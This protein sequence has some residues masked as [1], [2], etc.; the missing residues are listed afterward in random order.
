MSNN[1]SPT[2]HWPALLLL[3]V[4][5]FGP[6]SAAVLTF[7]HAVTQNPWLTA[8]LIVIYELLVFLVT[9]FGKVWQRLEDPSAQG[10]ADWI[11]SRVG[12]WHAG[13]RRQ[14]YQRLIYRCRHLENKGLTTQ[15]PFAPELEQVFVDL[16]LEETT[17][18]SA[19]KGP[20][21]DTLRQ[22]V[23]LKNLQ[24]GTHSIWQCLTASELAN[25]QFVILGPAGSGKTTLSLH[26]VLALAGQT[27]E[28]LPPVVSSKVPVLL[29]LR[30]LVD[31]FEEQPN[32][33]LV[34]AIRKQMGPLEASSSWIYRQLAKRRCLILLD[35][36][37]EVA[38]VNMRRKM[39]VW[40]ERQMVDY[41][42]N[43]F[44]M[45]SRPL[46]YRNNPLRGVATF[47][48]QP[49]TPKQIEQFLHN[50][51]L[52]DE[53]MRT[54][55]D[56]PGVHTKAAEDAK[57][58]FQRLQK[59]PA[60]LA[61]ATNPL[62]LT[63]IATVHRYRSSLPGSRV[64]LYREMCEY[65]LSK[66][67]EAKGIPQVLTAKQ[68]LSVLQ[69]LAYHM[70][71]EGKREV[72]RAA[73]CQIIK[74]PLAMVSPS[75][76]PEAFLRLIEE[77][78]GL[79]LEQEN[80]LYGFAHLTFQE[81]LTAA[82]LSE[83]QQGEQLVAHIDVEWWE[84]TIRLY[85][86]QADATPI[87]RACLARDHLS[88]TRL[89]LALEC[90]DEA[91]AVEPAIGEQLDKFLEQAVEAPDPDLRKVAAQALLTQRLR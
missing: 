75:M 29:F 73:A 46:G 11:K 70:M 1:S 41:G 19:L 44:V 13:Y 78:S 14:Y 61:L 85:C 67:Q 25:Q 21:S 80:D 9:F 38:D 5:V 15:S 55:K 30:E 63:M 51:Y 39:V 91:F 90:R 88:A 53:I 33:S 74:T 24:V 54:H 42:G 86:A 34:D 56:D 84:E 18:Q 6:P 66:R 40:V 23:K 77:T 69:V 36:L 31:M 64:D 60:L 43:R 68:K 45:T 32:F 87:L 62:L 16:R 50:W 58:L 52:I 47:Q 12:E 37:D 28:Q 3:A 4:A 76:Q 27:K 83:K 10:I 22:P 59:L 82:Y 65:L 71:R 8:I 48:A 20:V 35:G 57:D 7:T 17:P 26:I 2:N 72:S 81:Y 49:F 89:A 79:L